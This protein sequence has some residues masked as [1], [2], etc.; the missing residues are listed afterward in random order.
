MISMT[1]STL[2]DRDPDITLH[3]AFH[4]EREC[5]YEH[6]PF[7]V[8]DDVDQLLIDIAYNDRISSDPFMRGGNTLDIG[9]FDQQGTESRSPGFRG[10]SGSEKTR[11]V[12]GGDWSTPP[13]RRGRPEAGTWHLLLGPYK[14]GPS[15]LRWE[16]R[17]WLNPGVPTP[18]PVSMPDIAAIYRPQLPAAAEPGWYRGDL[19][20]H[21]IY[22]D[23][24][25][26][27]VEVAVAAVEHG[28][29]FF[30]ITDHN[31]AQSPVGLVPQGE[32]WPV[33][34]PGVEVTTYAGHFNVWG[35]D[36][37]YDFRE[38]TAVGL[39]RAVDEALADGGTLSLNHPRPFGPEW[40]YPEVT[41]FHAIEAWNGWWARF[42]AA[43]LVWWQRQLGAVGALPMIGGSDMHQH[44]SHGAPDRPLD[45]PRIG[46]PTTW[47]QVD[48]ALT[49][50]AILD[51]VRTGRSFVSESPSGPQ[52][53][54]L[55][56]GD[57]VRLRVAHAA[58]NALLLVGPAGVVHAEAIGRDDEVIALPKAELRGRAGES[59][60]QPYVR[61]EIHAVGG[62][63]RALGQAIRV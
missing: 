29:D 11:I 38:P 1:D 61:P 20:M 59:V 35:T 44:R 4:E 50:D 28:L 54:D 40:E 41:G 19:H 2:P 3:G 53:F 47:V 24:A 27:P 17:V 56:D 10:W 32:G 18:E 60:S 55:S 21:T 51:A 12:I 13:Y 31:R 37:W 43:S 30:G 46:Y 34:V 36:H 57:A 39:Q 5:S 6:V 45:P 52:L 15:G 48:G 9:L 7:E 26:T 22:S 23:G 49:V 8:P 42:N 62:A 33:L 58:G 14:I 25:G 63:V 16:A